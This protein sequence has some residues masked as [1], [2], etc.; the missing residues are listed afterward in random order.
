M[1][2]PEIATQFVVSNDDDQNPSFNVWDLRKTDYPV[3]TFQNI[4][5]SG[6]TSISWCL[7]DPN[8][9][10]STGRDDRTV[11][12]NFKSRE[13][14]MEFPNTSTSY[15]SVTWSQHLQGKLAALDSQGNTDVL[16]FQPQSQQS[17]GQPRQAGAEESFAVPMPNQQT[18]I[19]Y[20]PK[21]L[22]PKCGARFG[23]GGK[24]VSF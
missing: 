19:P 21:W 20:T 4:H 5:Y 6:I 3:S 12:T 24:L 23:F 11:I 18:G 14:V 7:A 1:W 9:V 2:N 13:M 8:L 22:K 17:V 16:S 10:A 15:E